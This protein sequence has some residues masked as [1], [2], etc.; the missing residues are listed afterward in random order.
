MVHSWIGIPPVFH[1]FL[2]LTHDAE[3]YRYFY[4]GGPNTFIGYNYDEFSGPNILILRY[5]DYFH[6]NRFLSLVGIVNAGNIWEDYKR[7]NLSKVEK[8]GYGLGVRIRTFVGPFQYV[9]SLGEK[10]TV[11]YFTFGY[12]LT[13]RNDDRK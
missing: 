1:L 13:T 8:I 4:L 2:G 11:H 10:Q 5:E 3:L 6:L 9:L 7:M 12:S